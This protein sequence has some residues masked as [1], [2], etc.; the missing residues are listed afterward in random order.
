M[1][2]EMR[3]RKTL[4]PLG[5]ELI[6]RL[7]DDNKPIF[8]IDDVQRIL[9][10]KPNEAADFLSELTRKKILAR[11]KAGKFLII[12]Q[13]LGSAER[14][15]GNWYVAAR[16]IANSP[17]YYV[18]FYSAMQFWGMLTQPLLKI[19]VATPK[20]Q[21]VPFGLRDR[22]IFIFI[23]EKFVWG[24]QEQWVTQ[25]ERV[26]ISNLEKTVLDALAHPEYCGGI[27]EAAKGIWLVRD[28]IDF[29]KL[30]DYVGRHEKIVVAKRLGYILEILKIDQ[31]ELSA[32]LRMYVKDRYDLFDPALAANRIDKNAWRLIDNVG[33]KHLLNV[34]GH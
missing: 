31:P 14:Y 2:D 29:Q 6:A 8:K 13:E 4:G 24:V 18:A 21:I 33:R 16:E 26:R 15:I 22:L 27:I 25:T 28:K 23:K 17:D 1:V 11:L 9:G 34:I 3:N 32:F 20:R 7:Y 19:Y 12:P 10:K 5:A 30:K